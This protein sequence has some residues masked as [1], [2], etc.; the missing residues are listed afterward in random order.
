MKLRHALIP[1]AAAALPALLPSCSWNIGERIRSS[2]ALYVG[3][4]TRHPVGGE[5]YALP[6]DRAIG[7]RYAY[8]PEVTYRT[9]PAWVDKPV[10]F[11]APRESCDITPTGRTIL[12]RYGH[13]RG[14]GETVE[15][16]EKLPEGCIICPPEPG[17]EPYRRA[18]GTLRPQTDHELGDFED[19]RRTRGSTGAK[20]A[21]A[22]FDYVVDPVMTVG[23]TAAGTLVGLAALCIY[24]PV[25]AVC[26]S[27][28]HLFSSD[29]TEEPPEGAVLQKDGE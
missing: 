5:L 14:A 12:V 15:R 7:N 28:V 24:Y 27:V 10:Y 19:A 1:L 20:I 26:D 2:T 9:K 4:D 18:N 16:V 6:E 17:K 13:H 3:A 21:A 23:T 29:G 25:M 22:P 8:V 11:G